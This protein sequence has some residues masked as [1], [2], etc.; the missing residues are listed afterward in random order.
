MRKIRVGQ[1]GCAHD[2]AG[3]V[4]QS[5]RKLTDVFEVIGYAVPEG[6]A[7]RS[8]DHP[9]TLYDGL[10]RM[11][12]EELL[13][14]PGL[15]A[16]IVET[17]EP[18]LTR[19]ALAAARRGLPVHMDKPGGLD[20]AEFRELVRTAKEKRSILH[21]GYMYRY[22]PEVQ[23]L[24]REIKEGKLGEIYSVEAQMNC[25]HQSQKRAWL[26]KFPGGMLFFL[27]CHLIDLIY[28][29]QGEPE[30]V[31][32]LSCATG[33]DGVTAED[34]GM[35]V[36]RYKNGVSFAKSCAAE[37]GGF[38]RRQLVVCGSRGTVQLLPFEIYSP[39]GGV[40]T[41]VREIFDNPGWGYDGE[42]RQTAFP[43]RYDGMMRAFAEYVTGEKEN[44]Y[45][46][47]SELAVYRLL[48]RACGVKIREE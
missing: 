33:I 28:R 24:L 15:D 36:M 18:N 22:N 17:S 27:G 30:E 16:V 34:F 39:D 5:L 14:A 10:R 11:T 13:D 41:C 1:I 2:H 40:A 48:L 29:I 47:D 8:Y 45:S 20:Y 4:I 38:L 37:Q 43:D 26:G 42:R 3:C 25:A 44:P 35:A 21:L 12:P 7:A 23:K 46:Y 31:I 32:P 6:E 19:Y 9:E